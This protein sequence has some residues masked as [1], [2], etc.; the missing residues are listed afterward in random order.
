MVMPA[1]RIEDDVERVEQLIRDGEGHI[2][3]QRE[4]IALLDGGGLSTDKARA[5]LAF[6]EEMVA[7]SKDHLAR[8]TD[9][10]NARRS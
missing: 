9:S 2:A 1:Q 4:L 6:L 5:F 3:R 10:R 7:M 8:L